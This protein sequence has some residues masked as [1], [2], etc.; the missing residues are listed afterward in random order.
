MIENFQTEKLEHSAV[1]LTITVSAESAESVYKDLLSKYSRE[2]QIPGFRKGKVP[3]S[4]LERKYGEGIRQEASGELVESAMEE[5]F[6]SEDLKEENPVSRPVLGELPELKPG[7][8]F[9]FSV[10]YDNFPEITLPEYKGIEV[11]EDQVEIGEKHINQD[12]E[13]I[14][15]QNAVVVEKKDGIVEDGSVVT[16]DFVEVDEDGNEISDSRRDGFVCT[17]GKNDH[18]YNVE[19]QLV[20]M[21]TDE[22][23]VIE[24]L[25][26]ENE[27][28][29]ESPDPSVYLKVTIK[30]VKEREL[31][32]LDDELA[33]DYSDEFKTLDELKE[34][35][36]KDIRE[37]ADSRLRTRKI[38][39]L[40]DKILE[41]TQIDVPR[42]MVDAELEARWS[43][44]TGRMGLSPQNVEKLMAE[45]GTGKADILKDWEEE[46]DKAVRTRLMCGKIIEDEKIEVSADDVNAEI[47][48]RA[49]R[50]N[51]SVEDF[52]KLFGGPR[53]RDYIR[54]E[55][56]Q[57]KL[58][59][60][61]LESAAVIKGSTID[62]SDLIG[63]KA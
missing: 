45:N 21:K 55:M 48:R 43:D 10:T 35:L 18:P 59:D 16:M 1:R 26:S 7:E 22:T 9:E 11:E 34:H 50:V 13:N 20:G 52:E 38:N 27:D 62:Y 25:P 47:K 46:A 54:N 31:P 61:L 28:D 37:H 49:D 36:K 17:I 19:K 5:A 29:T 53:I 39:Q 8:P 14:R 63:A 12:L 24:I 30:A 44:Y 15:E 3:A 57:E 33:Q 58:F 23:R 2:A 32:E 60:Y 40:T 41:G 56:V 42:S 4:L 6:E 51:V